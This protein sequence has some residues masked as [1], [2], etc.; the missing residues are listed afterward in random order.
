M[1][2]VVEQLV[3][4]VCPFCRS[5]DLYLDVCAWDSVSSE[6]PDNKD[7]LYEHQCN[8]CGLSFWT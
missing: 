8:G 2:D 7:V 1:V 5:E 6:D 3:I 4:I